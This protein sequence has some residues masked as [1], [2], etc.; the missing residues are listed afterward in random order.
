MII[1]KYIFN[2]LRLIIIKMF[3]NV[4]MINNNIMQMQ[5]LINMNME[6]TNIQNKF[7]LFLMQIQNNGL[8]QDANNQINNISFDFINFGIKLF[9]IGTQT[10]NYS[11]NNKL[12]IIEKV[13]NIIDNLN[14]IKKSLYNRNR[15]ID[16]NA[17]LN[18]PIFQENIYTPKYNVGFEMTNGDKYLIVCEGDKTVDYLIKEF[19]KRIGRT[20]LF[21]NED[22]EYY[23]IY[24]AK[25]FNTKENKQKK[26]NQIFVGATNHIVKVKIL[27]EEKIY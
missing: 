2:K 12:S 22:I 11:E 24:N 14:T 23:F 8:F 10:N 27:G 3:Q 17:N 25:K 13:D 1:K 20:D 16:I 5:N 18:N 7:N 4:N 9:N 15:W 6:L 26:I 21:D 19:L